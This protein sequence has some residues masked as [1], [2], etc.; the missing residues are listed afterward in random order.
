MRTLRRNWQT[1]YYCQYIS[2][3]VPGDTSVAGVAISGISVIDDDEQNVNY[4]RD[5]YG[6]LDGE[7][8]PY[9]TAP[10]QYRANISPAVGAV[11]EEMYGKL[12]NY[13]KVIVTELSCPINEKSVLFIGK[14]PE[15]TE[16]TTYEYDED[17][18]EY[19]EKTYSVP[20][21]NYIVE[22]VSTSLNS[23]TI[24]IRQV[25]VG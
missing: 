15:M 13:D 9:Y 19:V 17:E 25:P 18:K 16:A 8:I 4:V 3:R 2:D 21:Y 23:K 7:T 6:N 14:D 5:E 1:F 12:E 24:A 20:A 10:V 22:R 11:Q